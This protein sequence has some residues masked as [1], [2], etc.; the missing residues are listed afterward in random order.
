MLHHHLPLL[1]SRA[2][3]FGRRALDYYQATIRLAVVNLRRVAPFPQLGGAGAKPA[4]I[5]RALV[6]RGRQRQASVSSFT[7]TFSKTPALSSSGSLEQTLGSAFQQFDSAVSH[8]YVSTRDLV[9]FSFRHPEITA[10]SSQQAVPPAPRIFGRQVITR[11]LIRDPIERIR[12]IY[13]TLY[14][15]RK[16]AAGKAKCRHF[17][18]GP[19]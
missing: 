17:L 4:S 3:I 16:C 6:A 15:S 2:A 19:A 18:A 12:S 5:R 7:I 13:G 8:G 9:E 14:R 10:I 1:L 11:V